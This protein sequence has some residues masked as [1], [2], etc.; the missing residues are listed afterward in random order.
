MSVVD[1]LNTVQFEIITYGKGN[2]QTKWHPLLIPKYEKDKIYNGTEYDF[3][4]RAGTFFDRKFPK[5]RH[6]TL[7]FAFVGVDNDKEANNFELAADNSHY[8]TI[9]HPLYGKFTG[10]PLNIHFD[11]SNLTSTIVTVSLIDTIIVE[12]NIFTNKQDAVEA[13]N[14]SAKKNHDIELV[15][16]SNT[17]YSTFL[18]SIHLSLEIQ[19]LRYM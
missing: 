10:Q 13:I 17:T 14:S 15:L 16:L 18:G 8:W 9:T 19:P 11:N 12:N 6:I 5:G 4:D 2:V 3:I 1:R 7:D